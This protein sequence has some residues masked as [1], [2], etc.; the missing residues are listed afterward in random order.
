LINFLVN[1]E[2][3]DS[4]TAPEYM[5]SV[6]LPYY[7]NNLF[8]RF[9]GIDFNNGRKVKY[10]YQLVGWDKDWIHSKELNEVRYSN[11]AS[12]NYTFKVKASNNSGIWTKEYSNPLSK[13]IPLKKT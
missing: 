6:D 2:N 10:M 1:E 4:T 13:F 11:L 9:R 8:F 3:A 7:K 12:G 5:T